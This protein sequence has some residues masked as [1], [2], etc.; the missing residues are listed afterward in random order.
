MS[1]AE[2]TFTILAVATVVF[3]IGAGVCY[4][5]GL[6]GTGWALGVLAVIALIA[7]GPAMEVADTF[8]SE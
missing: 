3:G 8:K 1:K 4:D 7:S 2:K 5:L 6:A